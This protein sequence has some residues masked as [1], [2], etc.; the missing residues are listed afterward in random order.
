MLDTISQ[1]VFWEDKHSFSPIFLTSREKIQEI[2]RWLDEEEFVFDTNTFTEYWLNSIVEWYRNGVYTTAV[3]IINEKHWAIN[4][5]QK[6]EEAKR[7]KQVQEYED[8]FNDLLS[9]LE[10]WAK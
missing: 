3:R 8:R 4:S 1:E 9:E 6:W 10:L 2:L 7:Q 5:F